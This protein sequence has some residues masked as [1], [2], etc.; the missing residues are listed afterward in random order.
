MKSRIISVAYGL[1][2]SALVVLASSCGGGSSSPSPTTYLAYCG[3]GTYR[4]SQVSQADAQ[5]Q[6]PVPKTA[7]CYDQS[8]RT[9]YVSQEVAEMLCPSNV[10]QASTYEPDRKSAFDRLN[11]DR[12]KCGFGSVK[13]NALLDQAANNHSNYL[14]IHQVDQHEETFGRE[15][16]TGYFPGDRMLH[17]GYT[18]FWASEGLPG[19]LQWGSAFQQTPPLFW[20][21]TSE[22]VAANG[23][24]RLYTGPYHLANL[25]NG[26][27]EIGIGAATV[28]NSNGNLTAFKKWYTFDYATAKGQ[29]NT[30]QTSNTVLTFPCDGQEDL[31][32]LQT[33]EIPDPFPGTDRV[34]NPYG[35]PVYIRSATGT[36]LNMT[37][38]TITSQ[39][40]GT[41]VPAVWL[42]RAN[43]PNFKLLGNQV[44]LSP[45]V[46]LADNTWY[47]VKL[48]GT[49]TGMVTSSNPTGRFDRIFSFKTSTYL[50]Q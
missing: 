36:T 34:K 27:R 12:V 37:V 44:F 14:K 19:Y 32:T 4:N 40:D 13:Q 29:V 10:I 7:I 20:V 3:D 18:P 1:A 25:V 48:A 45:T 28:D 9:S 8:T 39:R 15:G 38:G 33:N 22:P 30:E 11:A 24:R 6:C 35:M 41:V 26:Y 49:N 2:L 46:G 47:D 42:T 23:L 21:Y 31:P 50:G 17:V 43:D 5:A 16:Y